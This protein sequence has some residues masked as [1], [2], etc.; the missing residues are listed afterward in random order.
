MLQLTAEA[1]VYRASKVS[2]RSIVLVYAFSPFRQ[3]CATC[4]SIITLVFPNST[5]G[6]WV[7]IENAA[8]I[9]ADLSFHFTRLFRHKEVK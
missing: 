1:P 5:C 2:F 9:E 4:P 8:D 7:V 6:D 3:L